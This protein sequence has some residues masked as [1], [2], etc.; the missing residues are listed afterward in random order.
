MS[1]YYFNLRKFLSRLCFIQ[2][3]SI[4]L[5]LFILFYH[6]LHGQRIEMQLDSTDYPPS[7]AVIQKINSKDIKFGIYDANGNGV[8]NEIGEDGIS[9]VDRENGQVAS[10]HFKNGIIMTIYD[11][12]FKVVDVKANNSEYS[13]T[14]DSIDFQ[15]QADLV[16]RNYLP[17]FEFKGLFQDTIYNL[18]NFP[19]D[20]FEYVY[21][22]VWSPF[23]APCVEEIPL[24][25]DLL[26]YKI[27]I[28]HLTVEDYKESAAKMILEKKA[29]IGVFGVISWKERKFLNFRAFPDGALYDKSGKLIFYYGNIPSLLN[30]L[31]RKKYKTDTR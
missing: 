29:Q 28:V 20:S 9:I 1:Y 27:Q 14:I 21:V 19:S 30:Y 2:R 8:F 12:S 10:C 3:H 17:S 25:K 4:S 31:H 13:L 16:L 26:E 15:E 7:K 24:F 6:T 5:C 18:E 11:Q 22:S 23:C